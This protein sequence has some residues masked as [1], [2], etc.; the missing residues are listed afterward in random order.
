M[1]K[2]YILFISN[3]TKKTNEDSL[4]NE[5]L[6]NIMNEEMAYERADK[7][8]YFRDINLSPILKTNNDDTDVNIV[9][10]KFRKSLSG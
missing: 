10:T 7:Y 6:K 2:L 1:I 9:L 4:R 3:I 8:A 5:P